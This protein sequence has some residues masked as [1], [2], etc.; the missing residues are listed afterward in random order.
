[1]EKPRVLVQLDTDDHASSFD[2]IAA[3]DA[4]VEHLLQYSAVEPTQVPPLVHGAIF[5]R[6]LADLSRT[7]IF[8]GGSNVAQ[9]QE[10]AEEVIHSFVGPMQVSVMFDPNGCNTTAAAAVLSAGRHVDFHRSKAL[11]LGGTGPVGRR[12]A[13]LLAR[14]GAAVRL[15]SRDEH[16]AEEAA[17]IVRDAFPDARVDAVAL[18]GGSAVLNAMDTCQLLF[19][20]GAA[21][22]Q[23]VDAVSYLKAPTSLK[24]LVDLNAVPP[25]GIDGVEPDHRAYHHENRVQYGAIGIGTLKMKIHRA[26]LARLFTVNDLYLDADEML[27]IGRELVKT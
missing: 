9:A 5:T 22:V 25:L 19:A 21:G 1:M 3:I 24:V 10:V 8:V 16:R 13:R 2:A 14:E 15:A 20:C 23:M 18:H 26:A 12:I 7:A 27:A 6:G 17:Q 11:V 4:G